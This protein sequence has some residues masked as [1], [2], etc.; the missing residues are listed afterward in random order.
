MAGRPPARTACARA[1]SPLAAFGSS[2]SLTLPA[3]EWPLDEGRR[4]GFFSPAQDL[5]DVGAA[6]KA[7]RPGGHVM[8]VWI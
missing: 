3:N 1:N 2:R 8:V 5:P 7:L 4:S 6:D